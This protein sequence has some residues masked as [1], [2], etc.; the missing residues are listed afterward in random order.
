M[1]MKNLIVSPYNEKWSLEFQK[2]YD[3]LF[4]ILCGSI[5]SIEHVGSTSV[6]GLSAK[7]IIDID[8]V[9]DNDMFKTVKNR[10]ESLGYKHEGDLGIEGRE[11]FEYDD[12][13]Q[14]MKHQLYVCNKNSAELKRHISFR[15]WLRTHDKDR[16]AYGK[17][18]MQMAKKFPNDI[19]GYM[20]GK[21]SC[22][23][24]I[25]KKCG[26]CKL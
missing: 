24:E 22:I 3:E 16:D 1:K 4:D 25:Y 17:I 2:I 5:I 13:P 10:L 19:E 7:P 12:K 8:V 20:V 6:K 23:L 18:K 9:I 11:A 26:L 14:L 21:Q 15:D